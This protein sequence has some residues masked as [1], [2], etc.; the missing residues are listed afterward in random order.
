MY[1]NPFWFGVLMTFDALIMITIV[2]AIVRTIRGDDD[3]EEEI[4]LSPEE[5]KKLLEE[6]TGRKFKVSVK[7]GFMIGEPEDEENDGKNKR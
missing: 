2:I 3:E 5:Y 6:M 1:V 4:E 7:G